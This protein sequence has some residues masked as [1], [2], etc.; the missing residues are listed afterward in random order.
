M[1]EASNV[2]IDNCCHCATTSLW[3]GN[4]ILVGVAA[5][6][7]QYQKRV[8]TKG[9]NRYHETST[10]AQTQSVALALATVGA[11]QFR[12]ERAQRIGS[13]LETQ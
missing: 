4:N 13:S 9:D 11:E 3:K 2:I 6:Q 5:I 8:L 1:N 7:V 12:S 10:W